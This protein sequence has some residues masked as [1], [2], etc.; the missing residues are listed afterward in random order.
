MKTDSA[1]AAALIRAE[2]KKA[3][4]GLK[5][6]CTSE[7]YSGGSSIRVAYE[8]QPKEVHQAIKTLAKKYQYGHF[9]GMNDIYEYSNVLDLP[10]AKYV[11][12]DNAMS[13]AKR[14]EYYQRLRTEWGGG[15]ELPATYEE[16]RNVHF[17]GSW[18]SQIVWQHFCEGR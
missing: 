3:F 17:Q 12:V 6:R 1:K 2:I 14:E 10:Q 16:G 5:F 11:F 8:D 15:D 13:D 4:P 7:T 18:V 9:D